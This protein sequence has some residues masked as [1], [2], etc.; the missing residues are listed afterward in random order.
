MTTFKLTSVALTLLC[1]L[2]SSLTHHHIGCL[3]VGRFPRAITPVCFECYRR[4]PN[5]PNGVGC[6]PLMPESDKCAFYVSLPQANDFGCGQCK[7]GY[8]FNFNTKKCVTGTIQNCAAE[9]FNQFKKS[10]CQGCLNG[11]ALLDGESMFTKKCIPP[12]QVPIAIKNCL[13]GGNYRPK[14]FDPLHNRD[15]PAFVSCFRCKPGFSL[16]YTDVETCQPAKYPGC[17]ENSRGGGTRCQACDVYDG[18][19]MQPD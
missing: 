14:G 9:Y 11:Y 16:T 13:W 8:A 6:G 17:M 2:G 7:P 10:Q 5:T 1:L 15:I 3:S 19:S 4:K 12:A 18:Y